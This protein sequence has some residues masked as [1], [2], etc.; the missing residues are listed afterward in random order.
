MVRF[1]AQGEPS[2]CWPRA[3][4]PAA[5]SATRGCQRAGVLRAIA[6]MA[7]EGPFTFGRASCTAQVAVWLAHGENDTVVPFATG[8]TSRA[9]WLSRNGVMKSAWR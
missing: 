4:A 1:H 2:V 3:T 6:P 8:V 5:A 7:T 9:G